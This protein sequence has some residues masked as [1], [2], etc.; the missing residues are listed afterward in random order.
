MSRIGELGEKC[1]NLPQ[2]LETYQK[3][4]VESKEHINI[5]GKK[6]EH[7]NRENP[8]W[9][10]YYDQRRIELKTLVK[11]MEA[12]VARVRSK[13]FK[14]LT[15]GHSIALS[16]RAK[17]KYIDSEPA[18]LHMDELRMEVEELYEQYNGIVKSFEARGY[19]L[20]NITELRIAALENVEV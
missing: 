3:D 13:L 4:I 18:F 11:Y 20:R 16:D 10:A 12:Q 15:E 9:Y 1:V 6:L 17:D 7:A 19:S 2:I 5:K 8:S 14:S